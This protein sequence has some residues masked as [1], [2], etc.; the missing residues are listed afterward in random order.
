MTPGALETHRLWPAGARDSFCRFNGV[1]PHKPGIL[2]GLASGRLSG[3]RPAVLATGAKT[4]GASNPPAVIT[5]AAE[6]FSFAEGQYAYASKTEKAWKGQ[7]RESLV[8]LADNT[9]ER[10]TFRF[11]S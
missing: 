1:L 6:P 11:K 3:R 10:A 7:C 2:F 8:Q 5:G 9:I 4:L